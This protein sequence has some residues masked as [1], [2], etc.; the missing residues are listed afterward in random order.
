MKNKLFILCLI[1]ISASGL[2]AKKTDNGSIVSEKKETIQNAKISAA[3]T[4]LILKEC[5]LEVKKADEKGSFNWKEAKSLCESYGEG[6]RLPT[7]DELKCLYTNKD[8]VGGF[9]RDWYWSSDRVGQF[10]I[11][12]QSFSN[13]K[14][15]GYSNSNSAKV[16]CVRSIKK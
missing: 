13:G 9:L 7:K 15:F 16:R 1:I 6:W 2:S 11:W 14:Q 5:S 12:V 8:N 10:N 3:E 4:S